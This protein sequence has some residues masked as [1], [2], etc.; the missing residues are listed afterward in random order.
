MKTYQEVK[1]LSRQNLFFSHQEFLGV[2]FLLVWEDEV[3]GFSSHIEGHGE[4]QTS[5]VKF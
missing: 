3:E 2:S 1:E 5:L 4:D